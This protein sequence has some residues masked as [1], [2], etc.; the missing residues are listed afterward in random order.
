[1]VLNSRHGRSFLISLPA[2]V[3]P[4]GL[5][6]VSGIIRFFSCTVKEFQEGL[7]GNQCNNL[8]LR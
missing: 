7:A 6:Y 8:R 5:F 2:L 1:M 3:N 4:G